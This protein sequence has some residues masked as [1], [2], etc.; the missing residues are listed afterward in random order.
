MATPKKQLATSCSIEWLNL[1]ALT[2][3]EGFNPREQKS[4]TEN[5]NEIAR[6]I[7]ARGIIDPSIHCIQYVERGGKKLVRNGHTLYAAAKKLG[8]KQVP[9]IATK[10]D[11]IQEIANLI[12]SNS[13][14]P[15]TPFEQGTVYIRLR[16]GSNNEKVGEEIRDPMNMAEIAKLF[17][18]SATHVSNCIALHEVS[19]EA[20]EF[21]IAG[22][23]SANAITAAR[24]NCEDEATI[25]KVLK[26]AIKKAD[27]EGKS[28]ATEKHVKEVKDQFVEVKMKGKSQNPEP[29][30]F[31]SKESGKDATAP[32]AGLDGLGGSTPPTINQ[33]L[34]FEQDSNSS[35]APPKK[36]GTRAEI[37]KQ[38]A[39][40]L[41]TEL[42][43]K[44]PFDELVDKLADII[45][46]F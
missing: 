10:M 18:I 17:G 19:G 23:I 8:K 22:K 11:S 45:S 38:I 43:A 16:D 3:E 9:A 5:V 4:F 37:K 14:H 34:D 21:L 2:I 13:G 27:D 12:I 15:L 40:V 35:C 33:G 41:R 30:T 36:T 39:L 6:L 1:T 24:R 29:K 46:P 28:V 42:D 7:E 25:L 44:T 31:K 32:D 26:A 20:R